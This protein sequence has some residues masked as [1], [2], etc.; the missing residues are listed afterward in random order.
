MRRA[1]GGK[2]L[3]RGYGDEGDGEMVGGRGA[4]P[5]RFTTMPPSKLDDPA[6]APDHPLITIDPHIP[7]M[8]FARL[9]EGAVGR[10]GAVVEGVIGRL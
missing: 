10:S 3:F 2:N 1:R 9:R 8:V 5:R 7:S 6:P 4:A